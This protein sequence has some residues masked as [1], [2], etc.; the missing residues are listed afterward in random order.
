[1]YISTCLYTQCI[2]AYVLC[3]NKTHNLTY[4]SCNFVLEA[5]MQSNVYEIDVFVKAQTKPTPPSPPKKSC[6]SPS[7]LKNITY[8]FL[9]GRIHNQ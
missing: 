8:L 4:I 3:V 6:I 2:Y 5:C 7:L 1:M 9:Y